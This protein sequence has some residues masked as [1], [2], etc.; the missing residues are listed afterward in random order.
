[1]CLQCEVLF[2][3][4]WCRRERNSHECV[5]DPGPALP[6]G[7]EGQIVSGDTTDESLQNAVFPPAHI[8]LRTS[9]S[10]TRLDIHVYY[11]Y[12]KITVMV[13]LDKP[14]IPG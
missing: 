14:A 3:P 2:L 7:F 4:K 8:P 5:S 13:G 12:M 1:M 10:S 6:E 9:S 11:V